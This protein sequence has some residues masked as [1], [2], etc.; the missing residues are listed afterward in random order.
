MYIYIYIYIVI[1]I[2][3]IIFVTTTT[4]TTTTTTIVN[5]HLQEEVQSGTLLR[6]VG[7]ACTFY[8]GEP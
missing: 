5:Y 4:T 6:E 2:I 1:I 8:E 3:I 7:S